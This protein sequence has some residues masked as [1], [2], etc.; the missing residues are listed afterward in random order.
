MTK[1]KI[2]LLIVTVAFVGF[3]GCGD[4][5]TTTPP[6]P[7]FYPKSGSQYNYKKNDLKADGTPDTSTTTTR[8]AKSQNDTSTYQG[9]SSVIHFV[10]TEGT[11]FQFIV[12]SSIYMAY[13][14]NNDVSLYRGTD[15]PGLPIMIP[16]SINPWWRMPV[17]SRTTVTIVDTSNM[18]LQLN[19]GVPI[20]VK[21][22]VGKAK[23]SGTEN[24]IVGTETLLCENTDVQFIVTTDV[25]GFG[26][27]ILDFT[28][29]YS[30]SAKIG[31]F[32]KYKV[33]YPSV[34]SLILGAAAPKN[35]VQVLTSYNLK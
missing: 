22:V 21:S 18:N 15:I 35:N 3:F 5:S 19:L 17:S 12:D 11:T 32:A 30:Y 4:S 10:E 27:I 1:F 25:T 28:T 20:T 6:T 24:V 9:K 29:T 26:T 14:S 13:E 8:T 31:Y 7:K 16:I 2:T 23:S 34:L 33:L